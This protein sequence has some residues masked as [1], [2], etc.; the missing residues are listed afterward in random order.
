M[1]QF[2]KGALISYIGILGTN[3]AGLI[4]TPYII[5]TLGDSDYG[6]YMLVGS[7]ISYLI[8]LDFG[9]NNAIARYVTKY[10]ID[11]DSE[12]EENLLAH[13][14]VT[15]TGLVVFAVLIGLLI[16]INFENYFYDSLTV[17]EIKLAKELLPFLI[18]NI[19]MVLPSSMFTAYSHAK[20]RFVYP[21]LINLFKIVFRS[22]IVFLALYNGHKALAIVIIDTI[23]NFMVTL[24]LIT[25][26]VKKLNFKIKLHKWNKILWMEI[27]YY[28]FWIFLASI[29]LKLQWQ[30]G[31]TIVGLQI[32]AVAVAVFGVGI[33]LG[34]YY[35]AFAFAINSMVL[36]RAV[37]LVE[38]K[39]SGKAITEDMI[40]VARYIL[41]ILFLVSSGFF[42]FGEK[43][44][45]LWLDQGYG[46]AY[47]IAMMI[48]ITR[49]IPLSQIYGNSIL[50]AKNKNRFK[51]LISLMTISIASILAYNLAPLYG[52][53]GVFWPIMIAMF[54]DAIIMN[55]YYYR[56]FDFDIF[57]FFKKTIFSFFT[58]LLVLILTFYLLILF[59]DIDISN[60]FNF[61]VLCCLYGLSYLITIF[62]FV[63][64]KRE[65]QLLINTLK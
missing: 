54:I 13:V 25:F 34:G 46:E 5:K 6:V 17:S 44:I 27:L 26:C 50:E 41:F 36:P 22:I 30:V 35:N 47:F 23:F 32:N 8:A 55:Y 37:N 42:L 40:T 9:L 31:Q 45:L 1:S 2:K 58:P 38:K 65:K 21:K 10:S 60:W 56:I 33:M 57:N 48:M 11:N 28:S 7:M 4:L 62:Y 59:L 12:S 15:L 29:V 19:L 3:L 24:F 52:L 14:F 43:F 63:L 20:Q 64:N 18:I 39:Y 16:F 61:F 51:S 53:D 49:T